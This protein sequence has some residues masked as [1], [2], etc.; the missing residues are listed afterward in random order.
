[1]HILYFVAWLHDQ[2]KSL[3]TISTYLA[4]ISYHNWIREIPDPTQFFIIKKLIKGEQRLSGTPDVRLPITPNILHK[5]VK[6]LHF[7]VSGKYTKRFLRAMFTLGF[8]AFLRIGEI[9][10]KSSKTHK[11]IFQFHNLTVDESFGQKKSLT[12]TLRHFK[13]HDSCRPVCLQ[14]SPQ[15]SKHI[16]PLRALVRYLKVRGNSQGPLFT[17]DGLSPIRQSFSYI[18]T[19]K[20][21]FICW[22]GL[23]KLQIAQFS[24]RGSF[25]CISEHQIRLMGR[26]NP[27]AVKRYFRIPVFNAI[28]VS[29]EVRLSEAADKV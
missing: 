27:S 19:Q 15:S 23:Q 1:M 22:F 21:H 16:C 24:D 13:H 18:R 14:I 12:L 3:N 9:S 29:P 26:W 20:C 5:L 6:S 4:G 11:N 25:L 8:F 7:T 28:D 17:F 2:K 10:A